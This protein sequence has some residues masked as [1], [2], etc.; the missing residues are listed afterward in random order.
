V[1]RRRSSAFV[2]VNS[3]RVCKFFVCTI[4]AVH[5]HV[6]HAATRENKGSVLPHGQIQGQLKGGQENELDKRTRDTT[7]FVGQA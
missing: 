6:G 2:Q 5:E 3:T 4:K 7:C 1:R